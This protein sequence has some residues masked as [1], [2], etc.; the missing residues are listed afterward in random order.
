[1]FKLNVIFFPICLGACVTM[2]LL[3]IDIFGASNIKTYTFITHISLFVVTI[4]Y[5]LCT[6]MVWANIPFTLIEKFY[7]VSFSLSFFVGAM[8]WIMSFVDPNSLN[9]PQYRKPF[10]FDF[11]VH[12]GTFLILFLEHFIWHKHIFTIKCHYVFHFFLALGLTAVVYVPW[13][14]NGFAIYPFIKK[15]TPV[16]FVLLPIEC[17]LLIFIGIFIYT[18]FASTGASN[19][20][21]TN[22]L[23]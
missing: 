8:Y 2:V 3:A 20:E 6:L 5:F 13:F 22:L 1:M 11:F 17:I 12:G 10:Y 14:L 15:Y 19:E 9:E 7:K 4:Y 21:S 23:V 16:E 18:K